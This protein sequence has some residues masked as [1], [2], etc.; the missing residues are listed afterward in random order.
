EKEKLKF[1]ARIPLTLKSEE[2][3]K[4]TL[5]IAREQPVLLSPTPIT[6]D[7]IN[8]TNVS[9]PPSESDLIKPNQ[10]SFTLAQTT[11]VVF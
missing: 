8:M 3:Q 5:G 11:K 4:S 6:T 7:T 9:K 10:L 1:N 2:Q